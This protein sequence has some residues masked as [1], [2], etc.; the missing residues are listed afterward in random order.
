MATATHAWRRGRAGRRSATLRASRAGG[1]QR[2]A[3]RGTCRRP[4]SAARGS[5]GRWR[6]D[7]DRGRA[8]RADEHARDHPL[9]RSRRRRARTASTTST[10]RRDRRAR[11]VTVDT[12]DHGVPLR[13]SSRMLGSSSGSTV[14]SLVATVT[15]IVPQ[16]PRA[17]ASVDLGRGFLGLGLDPPVAH[18]H[19][20]I[21]RGGD[22]VVV[23]DDAGSSGRRRGGA[24]TARAPRGRLRSR[25]RRWARRRAA[26]SARWRARARS[27]AAGAAHRRARPVRP[28]PCRRGRGG[29]AG[30]ARASRARLRGAPAITAGS[31]TFSSTLM[32]SSRLKNWNTIPMCRRRRIASS[33]SRLADQ[34]L[35]RQRHLTV[36]RR[37]EPG[38]E[39]EQRR[40]PATRRPHHRDE[41]GRAHREVDAAQRAHRRALRFERLAQTRA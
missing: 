32:P 35:A 8:P 13:A 6:A 9:G 38:D 16:V 40:L 37:V 2:D 1:E 41:L 7:E 28:S 26:A 30:R 4:S 3:R 33:S 23:R 36:G 17:S 34:R 25:A 31:V 20:A 5:S 21:G 15:P 19:D 22:V 18:A 10:A 39:V 24:G 11:T 12:A 14:S 27:R 29:R